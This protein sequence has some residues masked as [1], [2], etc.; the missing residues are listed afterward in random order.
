MLRPYQT[1]AIDQ[2]RAAFNVRGS[3]RVLL[4]MATGSGKTVIFCYLLKKLAEAQQ[5]ALMIVRGRQLVDQASQRLDREGVDHG[6]LMAKHWRYR[7]KQAIQICSIDTLVSRQLTPHADM[8]IID[9]A[10]LATTGGYQK[11]LQNYPETPILGVTATPYLYMGGLAD[12]VIKPVSLLQLVEQGYLVGPRYYV[13][14]VP[15][16]SRVTI[17]RGDYNQMQLGEAMDR[18]ELLGDI[19]THWKVIGG[20]RP[21]LAFCVNVAHSRHLAARF[22][23]AGIPAAHCDADTPLAERNEKIAQLEQGKLK[24]L[25][26]V[27]IWAT[28]VDIPFL[29][30]IVLARPTQSYILFVQQLGRGTRA[31]DGKKDFLVLDHAGNV[32]RHGFIEQDPEAC[33]VKKEKKDAVPR[34]IQIKVCRECYAAYRGD[35]CPVCGAVKVM[36]IK[37]EKFWRLR[38]VKALTP[39]QEY[40]IQL[41]QT[42]RTKGYKRGWVWHRFVQKFGDQV[43]KQYFRPR[44]VPPW[45]LTRIQTS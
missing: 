8:I 3:K 34:G 4:H 28:G 14:T 13:P 42:A 7:P 36:E 22:C 11:F 45:V 12:T 32:L 16:V 35:K 19:L 30:C 15:D 24:V 44:K 2:I 20:D 33:L 26:N 43:A 40:I 18:G 41:K 9:E 17:Q 5:H 1:D 31:V 6:V 23:E 38:E 37:Q 21:S 10:H 29:G 39:E 25:T 27:N